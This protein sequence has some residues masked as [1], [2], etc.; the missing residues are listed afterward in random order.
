M[1]VTVQEPT[2]VVRETVLREPVPRSPALRRAWDRIP[3]NTEVLV[4]HGPPRGTCDGLHGHAL[5]DELLTA[6]V[7]RVAPLLHVCGH[8]HAGHGARRL[9]KTLVVNASICDDR[10]RPIYPPIVVDL[11]DDRAEVVS[12]G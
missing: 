9:S 7:L 12:G 1:H 8:I 10:H 4:T 6:R 5:G 2:A 3:A 11:N